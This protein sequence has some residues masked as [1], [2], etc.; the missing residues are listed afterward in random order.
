MSHQS[1]FLIKKKNFEKVRA[2]DCP[3]QITL[4]QGKYGNFGDEFLGKM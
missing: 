4:R 2:G 1:Y 3:S